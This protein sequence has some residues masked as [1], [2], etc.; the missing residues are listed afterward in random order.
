MS[1]GFAV[2]W[3]GRAFGGNPT[4]HKRKETQKEA[5]AVGDPA[6]FGF[7]PRAEDHGH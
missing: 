3:H 2:N 4:N 1:Q 6:P 5:V 7:D